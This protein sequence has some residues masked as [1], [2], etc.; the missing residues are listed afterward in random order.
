LLSLALQFL[1]RAGHRLNRLVSFRNTQPSGFISFLPG[2]D[3]NSTDRR[4]NALFDGQIEF[5]LLVI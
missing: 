2:L 3:L 5:A 1:D 4:L